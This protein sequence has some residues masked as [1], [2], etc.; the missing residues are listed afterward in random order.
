MGYKVRLIVFT[1]AEENNLHQ[2]T[3]T[4]EERE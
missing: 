1:E 2:Q 4:D 3:D